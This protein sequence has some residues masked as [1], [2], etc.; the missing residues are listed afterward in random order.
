M[1][2]PPKSHRERDLRQQLVNCF[3][4]FDPESTGRVHAA[5][6]QQS[7]DTVGLKFGDEVV[8]RVM[9]LCRIDDDGIVRCCRAH[10][11]T[12]CVGARAGWC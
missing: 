12:A 2:S 10:A 8:D 9:L 4:Y 11:S 6:F 1:Q 5:D 3:K 7:L